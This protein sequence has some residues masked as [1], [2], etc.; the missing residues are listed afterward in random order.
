MQYCSP[1]LLR[2]ARIKWGWSCFSSG[3]QAM[4]KV[5]RFLAK[6]SWCQRPTV[7]LWLSKYS[8][9]STW[10]VIRNS[11]TVSVVTLGHEAEIPLSS[12]L[13][14]LSVNNSAILKFSP[15]ACDVIVYFNR[16]DIAKCQCLHARL[17]SQCS[18]IEWYRN[19][20]TPLSRTAVPLTGT[21]VTRCCRSY[22]G[23]IGTYLVSTHSDRYS[24]FTFRTARY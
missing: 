7:A 4:E 8:S 15:S 6:T 21:A 11:V 14:K 19:N 1:I 18:R 22:N 10:A 5:S 13:F 3:L 24:T 16:T 12:E 23:N 2:I 9:N 20:G 17:R